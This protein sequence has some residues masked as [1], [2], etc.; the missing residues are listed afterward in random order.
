MA[1]PPRQEGQNVVKRLIAFQLAIT[2]ILSLLFTW[3]SAQASGSALLGGLVAVIPNCI[4]AYRVF[5][6]RGAQAAQAMVSALYRGEA[7]KL[8]I[9]ILLMILVFRFF[10]VVALAFFTTYIMALMVFW[11]FLLRVR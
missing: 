5:A 6:H 2:F 8:V 10:T 11:L 4:F 3:M 9:T 1:A 7:Q